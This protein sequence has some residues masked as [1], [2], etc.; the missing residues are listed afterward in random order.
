MPRGETRVE[1]H[2]LAPEGPIDGLTLLL[3]GLLG[4]MV[5]AGGFRELAEAGRPTEAGEEVRHLALP[6]VQRHLPEVGEDALLALLLSPGGPAGGRCRPRCSRPGLNNSFQPSS[7]TFGV[8]EENV[9][10]AVVSLQDPGRQ[11]RD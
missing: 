4:G 6:A 7:G 1:T 11:G 9:E 5:G 3:P 10:L 2:R 8:V